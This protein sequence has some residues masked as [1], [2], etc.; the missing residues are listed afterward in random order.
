MKTVIQSATAKTAYGQELPEPINFE[1]SYEKLDE[2]D[3]I[4]EDEIPTPK[5]IL[6]LVNTTR[7]AS[8]RSKA[9]MEA[10]VANKV[11]KP[12]LKDTEFAVSTMVKA[13]IA[14]G[15]ARDMAENI[16]RNALAGKP[17]V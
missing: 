7:A 2:N 1:F 17:A 12:D 16:A 11:K 8:A 9:Q 10:F 5:D 14:Q 6:G 3:V 15:F 13:L 4:P